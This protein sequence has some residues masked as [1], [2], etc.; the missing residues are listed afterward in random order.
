MKK[1]ETSDVL[2]SLGDEQLT[3]DARATL[4]SMRSDG[5]ANRELICVVKVC[6]CYYTARGEVRGRGE[7]ERSESLTGACWLCWVS[8]Q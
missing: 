2:T 7:V 1:D 4:R 8:G 3:L 6:C 5:A